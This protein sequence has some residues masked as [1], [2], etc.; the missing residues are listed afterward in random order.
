MERAQ[1]NVENPYPDFTDIIEDETFH[2][3][4]WMP[5]VMLRFVEREEQEYIQ[6]HVAKTHIVKY[7]QQMWETGVVNNSGTMQHVLNPGKREW[8]DVEV[9]DEASPW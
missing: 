9:K 4:C 8:R 1:L 5:T 6:P 3:V 2:G 7:L